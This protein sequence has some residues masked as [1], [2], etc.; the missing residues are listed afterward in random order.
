MEVGLLEAC[1]SLVIFQKGRNQTQ[2]GLKNVD[3]YPDAFVGF[4][5]S[6]LP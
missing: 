5:H 3:D 1:P 2:E 4:S 6:E